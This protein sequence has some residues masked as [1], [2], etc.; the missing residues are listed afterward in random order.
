[1]PPPRS[2]AA[3]NECFA[4]PGVVAFEAGAGGLPRAVV[5]A[6]DAVAHVYL[7]GAQVTHHQPVGEAPLLF[8][9]SRSRF[10]ASA[11]IRGGVPVVF[12]WFG[13]RAGDPSAPDHG[14]ARISEWTVES[15][16]QS[17]DG[18]VELTLG[19]DPSDVTRR[20]WPGE[21]RLR[22]TVRIAS[23]L[24]IALEVENRSPASFTFEEALHTYLR[25]GDVREVSVTGLEGVTYIDK[26]D[27]M[28][29]KT[30]PAEPLRLRAATDRVFVDTRSA[31]AVL[32]PR[33]GRRL[34]IDKR[35]SST[36]VVWNPW[37]DRAAAMTD[38]G[39]DE[40]RTMVCV[41]AA[42]AA[43]SAVTLAPGE[44]HAMGMVLRADR[45][46]GGRG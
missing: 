23:R 21:F 16:E 13:P 41:E 9:S 36:T 43:D 5:T 40:W 2:P 28:R 22:L 37:R 30:L 17:G 24:D 27:G 18:A 34:V 7:H 15:V 14:F 25:V 3:L 35:G 32:D 46:D 29:R 10:A 44:R 38:L 39:P 26:M 4:I 1:M 8:L 11:A 19:L 31:C 42:N 45:G 20:R 33:L 12:P 6:P